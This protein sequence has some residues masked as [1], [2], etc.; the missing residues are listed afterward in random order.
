M[1]PQHTAGSTPATGVGKEWG[2]AEARMKG[3]HTQRHNILPSAPSFPANL[4]AP[5]SLLLLGLPLE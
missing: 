1:H 3:A 4:G 2:P 5:A